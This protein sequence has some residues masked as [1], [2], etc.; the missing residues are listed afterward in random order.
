VDL[1]LDAR[2]VRRWFLVHK[3][4]SLIC[5]AFILLLCLTGLPLLFMDELDGLLYPSLEPSA[6]DD[7]TPMANLDTI[8]SAGLARKPG[9]AVQFILWDRND[10]STVR[11]AIGESATSLAAKNIVMRFDAHTGDYLDT[12]VVVGRLTHFIL[13]LHTE[14]FAGLP[15]KLF[16]GLMGLLFVTAIITGVVLYA[17]A[18]R[19]LQFG[20]VRYDRSS[21]LRWLDLHN[22]L[23][24]VT[25]MWVLVVGVTG[26]INTWAEIIQN[27][28]QRDQLADML[29]P[30]G[31]MSIPKKPASVEDAVNTAKK[32]LPDMMPYFVAYPGTG[33]TSKGHY[34]IFMR[35]DTALTSR[36]LQPALI[37]ASTGTFAATRKLPWYVFALLISQPL[38]FGDYGG[39]PLKIIWALLDI[40]TIILLLSGLFLW[41]G[42]GGRRKSSES[43]ALSG[44]S[45]RRLKQPQTPGVIF[46]APVIVALL[47]ASGLTAALMGDGIWD[48]ASWLALSV[49][50]AITLW[51]TRYQR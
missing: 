23:G 31:S 38:H 25:I 10:P 44:R 33:F 5:T 13:K 26:T 28:W 36:L 17:P 30:Y 41:L 9:A 40:A 2:T 8:V 35:G 4:T 1:I 32:N 29:R 49:P 3:W 34:A 37:D 51:F 22:L 27:V 19:R 45:D 50:I 16:L 14:L 7:G 15:G 42:R 47:A 21:R 18:M 48:A 6:V 12:P 46:R 43:N 20:T 24:A 11:L 39:L